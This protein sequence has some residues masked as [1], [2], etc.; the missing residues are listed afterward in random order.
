MSF[1]RKFNTLI[2][3]SD[4][5]ICEFSNDNGIELYIYDKN[6]EP[7][8]KKRLVTGMAFLILSLILIVMILYMEL[9]AARIIPYSI[10]TLVQNSYI[11]VNYLKV[12][13]L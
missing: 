3:K 13:T 12:L 11:R 8:C 9:L 1:K 2:R 10:S 7:I 4:N 5:S 6:K